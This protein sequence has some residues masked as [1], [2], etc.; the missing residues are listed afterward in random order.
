MVA[1]EPSLIES[2]SR[3]RPALAIVDLS[4]SRRGDLGWLARLRAGCPGLRVI[5]ISVHDEAEVARAAHAAGAEGFV[6]KRELV[7]ELLPA[8][9][10]VLAG[11]NFP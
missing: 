7:T 1:D 5:V 8:A 6:L 11:R 4:L 3:L 10:S 2:A 9:E